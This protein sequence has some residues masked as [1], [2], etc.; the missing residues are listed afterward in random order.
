ML[1]WHF[2]FVLK[3]RGFVVRASSRWGVYASKFFEKQPPAR[4]ILF[5]VSFLALIQEF[6]PTCTA[7]NLEE[8]TSNGCARSKEGIDKQA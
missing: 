3:I 2:G 7:G 5:G 6:L 8:S 1:D 4:Y